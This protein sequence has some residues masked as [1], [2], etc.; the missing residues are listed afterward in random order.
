MSV[1]QFTH[2]NVLVI[3]E[4]LNNMARAITVV[5]N[6]V[7]GKGKRSFTK[8]R[9]PNGFAISDY[10]EFGLFVA[11]EFLDISTGRITS[12]SVCVPMDLST[13]LFKAVA[14][15]T[16]DIFEKA[17]WTFQTVLVGFTSKFKLPTWDEQFTIPATDQID[18]SDV[19][20]AGFLTA[21]EAGIVTAGGTIVFTDS[22]GNQGDTNDIARELHRKS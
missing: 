20:V 5:F 22:R 7:D 13:G 10:Q 2:E 12:V 16:A 18:T 15:A 9:V 6:F 17:L 21:Y 3:L 8:V 4:R 14:D 11:Q 1:A 19:F